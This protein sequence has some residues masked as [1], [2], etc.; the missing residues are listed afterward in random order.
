MTR[1]IQRFSVSFAFVGLLAV[2]SL[3]PSAVAQDG[4]GRVWA[5]QLLSDLG[6]MSNEADGQTV[7]A[8]EYARN[9]GFYWASYDE[10]QAHLNQDGADEWR[11]DE[12]GD[13]L[14][15]FPPHMLQELWD[16][17][18]E[19]GLAD[20]AQRFEAHW[21]NASEFRQQEAVA[22][23]DIARRG[24]LSPG[25]PDY[26]PDV[27]YGA[28]GISAPGLPVN[29]LIEMSRP[30]FDEFGQKAIFIESTRRARDVVSIFAFRNGHW[31]RV[32]SLHWTIC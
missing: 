11:N 8:R 2:L 29:R 23:R 7:Y 14:R 19:G 5:C 13:A 28:C 1:K 10:F 12:W 17:W 21:G 15:A 3:F 6:R 20:C 4:P 18:N 25:H 22:I 24:L 27:H 32:T 30:V 16:S 26:I 9:N 31:E